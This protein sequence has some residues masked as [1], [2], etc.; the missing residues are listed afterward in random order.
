MTRLRAGDWVEVRSRA[1]ILATLDERGRL[2]GLPFMPEMF[3]FC[4]KRFQVYKRAH[5]TCDT[6]FPT[7]GRRVANAVHL[8]TRCTG[9]AH[10]GCQAGCLLFWKTAWL[11]TV[12]APVADG[13]RASLDHP[14]SAVSSAD[15][16]R[17]WTG[18]LKTSQPSDGL[19]YSCQATELPY[20]TTELKWWRL[21]QYFEDYTS[22]NVTIRELL[23]GAIYSTYYNL[24][25]AGLGLGP[26]MRWLWNRTR[27]IWGGTLFPRSG[28]LVE[29][30]Q[31]TPQRSLA[32]KSGEIVRVRPHEEI[33][34]T[35]NKEGKNRGMYWDAEMVP[36]CGGSYKVLQRVNKLLDEKTGKM[37]TL[38][39]EAIILEG[40]VCQG[41]YSGH[42]M[43]C[44]RALYPYWREAWLERVTDQS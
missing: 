2:E 14:E 41:K 43:F 37:I 32:L 1:E 20:F 3:A 31:P 34:R 13:D 39:N 11:K 40:V 18:I 28:G 21:T 36:Y 22:G 16:Q 19:A 26:P 29:L 44:P 24:S 17:V 4:G 30:G 33:L 27:S 35:V 42:R 6:V 10:G 15:D 8:D 7:R 12:H 5:K 25:Q 23:R 9:E 38:K